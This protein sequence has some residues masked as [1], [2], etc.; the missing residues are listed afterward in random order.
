MNILYNFHK[1]MM[2]YQI[3]PFT[4]KNK[5]TPSCP[6]NKFLLFLV[7]ITVNAGRKKNAENEIFKD[8]STALGR[9]EHLL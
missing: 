3:E 8:L 5:A 6:N 9:Y 4:L 7:K 2:S 1:D